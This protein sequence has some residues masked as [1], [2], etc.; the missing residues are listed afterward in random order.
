MKIEATVA[1]G[2]NSAPLAHQSHVAEQGWLDR[3]HVEPSHV[4]AWI[5][6]LEHQHLQPVIGD[7]A[8]VLHIDIFVRQRGV[9][10]RNI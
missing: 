7:L 9:V 8:R 4:A 3:K 2:A 1:Q 5:T 10:Q 6:T